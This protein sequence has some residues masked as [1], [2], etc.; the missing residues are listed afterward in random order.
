MANQYIL[1]LRRIVIGGTA[2]PPPLV[3]K[4]CYDIVG[5][6]DGNVKII[7]SYLALDQAK[8]D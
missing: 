5:D 6:C 2:Q 7:F 3:K 4:L 1:A 8:C